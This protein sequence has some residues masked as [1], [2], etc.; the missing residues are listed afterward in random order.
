MAIVPSSFNRPPVKQKQTSYDEPGGITEPTKR[1]YQKSYIRFLDFAYE[2]GMV[3]QYNI[4]DNK[5]VQIVFE[6][7]FNTYFS[8]PPY[9]K[10]PFAMVKEITEYNYRFLMY[11]IKKEFHNNPKYPCFIK[12]SLRELMELTNITTHDT[13]DTAADRLNKYLDILKKYHAI[14]SD[15]MDMEITSNEIHE[16]EVLSFRL[17]HFR[18]YPEP[19]EIED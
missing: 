13:L 15:D 3:K 8:E 16:N 10:I 17:Y 1:P 4:L 19:P 5:Y 2:A 18:T 11:F 9:I 12:I 14:R 7:G 6:D